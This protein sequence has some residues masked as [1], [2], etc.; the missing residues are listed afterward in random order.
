MQLITHRGVELSVETS[1]GN[2]FQL[3]GIAIEG[4]KISATA[5]IEENRC[6]V[7]GWRT[8]ADNPMNI[9][10]ELFTELDGHL[11]RAMHFYMKEELNRTQK[12][13]SK[14]KLESPFTKCSMLRANNG[15]FVRLDIRRF[16]SSADLD[17]L[18]D[19]PDQG[20]GQPYIGLE[21]GFN[22]FPKQA[23]GSKRA[24]A[25]ESPNPRRSKRAKKIQ[26]RAPVSYQ[27]DLDSEDNRLRE[28][29]TELKDAQ[30]A[31][32]KAFAAV[33]AKIVALKK[34]T[35]LLEEML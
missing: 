35:G 24:N 21:I 17:D 4:N 12:R 33:E 11:T 32:E 19:A 20:D 29:K 13:C 3:S 9:K 15:G 6:Y 16:K 14:D 1:D 27:S 8:V 30:K 22:T 28:L 34:R 25:D 31:E 18:I 10:C 2:R 26:P 23:A 5:E 7:A